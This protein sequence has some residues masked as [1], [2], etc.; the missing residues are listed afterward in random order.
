MGRGAARG[1]K[2]EC[3]PGAPPISR[4]GRAGARYFANPNSLPNLRKTILK[5]VSI[6]TPR[7]TRKL[8]GSVG[9]LYNSLI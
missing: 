7:V 6:W 8:P 1:C 3:Q 5:M 2:G 9:S 4:K